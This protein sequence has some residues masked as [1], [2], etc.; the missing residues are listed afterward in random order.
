MERAPQLTVIT[1]QFFGIPYANE[2]G[3]SLAEQAI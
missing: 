2:Q 1:G 3:I